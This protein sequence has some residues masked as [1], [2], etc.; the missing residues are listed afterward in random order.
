MLAHIHLLLNHFP[1]VGMVIA[2]GLFVTALIRNSSELKR[3]SLV[4]FVGL[5]LLTIPTYVTGNA[6]QEA[7]CRWPVGTPPTE[8]CTAA[9]VNQA[10]I[11]THEG[12]AMVG[13][14]GMELTGAFAWLGLWQIRR[15]GEAAKW[16]LGII[17][18]LAL[19]TFSV[20]ARVATIGGEI[21]HPEILSVVKN[22]KRVQQPAAEGAPL[23][24]MVGDFVEGKTWMWPTC[25]TLH[26][27][28]LSLL[29]GV[30]LLIDLRMLGLMKY[31]AFPSIHRVLPWGILGFGINVMTGMLFFIG[32]PQQYT[33][34]VAFHWKM[35]LVL[36]A[37]A[38]ALYFTVFDQAWELKPGDEAPLAAKLAAGSAILLWAGVMWCG[39]M[40]PFIG[41]AF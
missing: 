29:I 7:I 19:F 13:L 31:A 35:V 16:N 14:A 15:M 24:R 38:N 18:V 22:G 8:E 27:I 32:A 37:G 33:Q 25:E 26:F 30:V 34:N 3:D 10:T 4:I 20:M 40:L 9:A 17:T 36:I 5:A 2:I 11:Q 6:A 41:Q 1:T 23:A 12:W 39:N 28:G 21:R